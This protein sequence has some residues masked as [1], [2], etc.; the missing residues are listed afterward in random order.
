MEVDLLE[1]L[2]GL[3]GPNDAG[4]ALPSGVGGEEAD[5]DVLLLGL[6]GVDAENLIEEK[7]S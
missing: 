1:D 7:G 5:V 4:L 6:A 3:L 2:G